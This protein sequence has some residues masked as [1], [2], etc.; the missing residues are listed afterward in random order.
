MYSLDQDQG[1]VLES[2]FWGVRADHVLH[3]EGWAAGK[4]A[5]EGLCNVYSE[6]NTA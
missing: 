3:N 1:L 5:D 2:E 4:N 6:A